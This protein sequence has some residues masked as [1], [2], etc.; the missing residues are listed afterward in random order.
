MVLPRRGIL[1]AL[2]GIDGAGK[3][4]QARRLADA[5]GRVDIDVVLTK[6]PTDR[7]EHGRRIRASAL[8]GRLTLTEELHAFIEDRRH[9]V[10]TLIEPELAA[11]RVVIVDRY[12]FSTA[13]YQ[14]ARGADVAAI[15][16]RNEAFAP[17]PD[18]LVHLEVDASVGIDRIRSRGDVANAF[19]QEAD[20]RRCAELFG[21]MAFPFLLRLD[22]RLPEDAITRRILDAVWSGPLRD[23]LCGDGTTTCDG[24]HCVQRCDHPALWARLGIPEP[25]T[26][27][28]LGRIRDLVAQGGPAEG[29]IDG[30]VRIAREG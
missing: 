14:G 5:F 27:E 4:T 30:I 7:S 11:G 15:L 8:G 21:A 29:V 24:A 25:G 10:A 17:A 13:A 12:Y 23:R 26:D 3:T 28:L 2:E 22:G 1:I 20:L 9:H 16:R 19:E 6:E 18:V